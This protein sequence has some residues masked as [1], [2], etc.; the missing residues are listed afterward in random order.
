MPTSPSYWVE[1]EPEK[2]NGEGDHRGRSPQ[3]VGHRA[4]RASVLRL[5]PVSN[6]IA[7]LVAVEA[8]MK[9]ATAEL[10]TIVLA[11]G[12]RPM[13]IHGVGP[14]VAARILADVGDITRFADRT[15]SRPG[16]APHPLTPPPV[17]RMATGSPGPG[18]GG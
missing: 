2:R 7:D 16:P 11:R 18:T 9:K 14:V 15:G 4:S 12:S 5:W 3:A 8:K 10:K 1:E 13:D 17:S 6:K